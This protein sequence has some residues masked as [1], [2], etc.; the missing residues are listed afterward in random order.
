MMRGYGNER[1]RLFNYGGGAYFNRAAPEARQG[2]MGANMGIFSGLG[3]M[4]GVLGNQNWGS[5]F[6][7]GGGGMGGG[8]ESWG[9][10]GG[11]GGWGD[12]SSFYDPSET[13]DWY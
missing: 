9:E 11:D 13:G 3:G 12:W 5:L 2:Q 6:G 1:D 8:E 7:G 4:L 10:G